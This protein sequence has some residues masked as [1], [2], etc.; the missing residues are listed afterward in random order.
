MPNEKVVGLL[1]PGNMGAV[2]AHTLRQSGH[3]VLW[4]AEG[5][6]ER[7]RTRAAAAGLESAS[8]ARVCQQAEMVISVCPPEFAT[9]VCQQVL[10]AGYR[11]LF[12]DANAIQPARALTLDTLCRN[13]GAAFV[14]GGIIGPAVTTPQTTWLYLSGERAAQAAAYFASGPLVAETV[15]PAP[16]QA[17]GLKMCFA[18]YNK[19]RAALLAATLATAAHFGVRPI[20]YE[21]LE[22]RDGLTPAEAEDFVTRM[23]PRAWRF[24]A[25][26]HEIADTFESAGVTGQFHEG[27]AAIYDRL[28]EFKDAR[29]VPIEAVLKALLVRNS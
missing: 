14:D 27:A 12:V 28:R 3:R 11:R 22:R 5:R 13:A 6:S 26:M 8:I 20:I 24:V 1:H 17:S 18:A 10:H 16:G 25:E 15:G 21:Q 29:D 4:V 23:A 2:V 9:D 7:S 19:G